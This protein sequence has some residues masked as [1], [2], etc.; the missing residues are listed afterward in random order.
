MSPM[1]A[2]SPIS[3]WYAQASVRSPDSSAEV[4][5]RY[6]PQFQSGPGGPANWDRC[7]WCGTPRS[8]H[9]ADWSCASTGTSQRSRFL[10]SVIVAGVLALIGVVLLTLTSQTKSSLGTLGAAG[11]LSGLVV[12]ICTGTIVTR[13]R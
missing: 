6:G 2:I 4:P 11:L 3:P 10:W 12:L 13:R 9:G 8:T 5:V 7:N 1:S